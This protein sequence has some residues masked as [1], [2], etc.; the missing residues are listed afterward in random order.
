MY[1]K[2]NNNNNLTKIFQIK[3]LKIEITNKLKQRFI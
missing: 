3:K 1:A 2:S